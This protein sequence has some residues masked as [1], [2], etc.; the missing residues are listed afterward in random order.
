M[1]GSLPALRPL[2]KKIPGFL[3][4]IK[5]AAQSG[6]RLG[7]RSQNPSTAVKSDASRLSVALSSEASPPRRTDDGPFGSDPA[8]KG[9]HITL[10]AG[11]DPDDKEDVERQ[12]Q[13]TNR[14]TS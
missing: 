5:D 13:A 8:A 2:F 1:C 12:E 7:R 3:D 10:N 6:Y 4:N 11:I 9:L 14:P